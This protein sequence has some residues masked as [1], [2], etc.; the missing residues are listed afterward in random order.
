MAN[1]KEADVRFYIREFDDRGDELRIVVNGVDRP[2]T[3][4]DKKSYPGFYKALKIK[5]AHEPPRLN[6]EERKK[7]KEIRQR[8]ADVKALAEKLQKEGR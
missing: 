1:D 4:H 6:W 7:L 2:A 3:K 5:M 8:E